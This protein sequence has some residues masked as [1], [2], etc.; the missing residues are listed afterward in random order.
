MGWGDDSFGTIGEPLSKEARHRLTQ[1]CLEGIRREIRPMGLA[2]NSR[3]R[4]PSL[5]A[6]LARGL[7]VAQKTVHRWTNPDG[8]QANDAN[9]VNLARLS[10]KYDPEETA[11]VLQEDVE[12]YRRT[13]LVWLKLADSNISPSP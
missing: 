7:G 12:K 5:E 8:I 11:R 13:V 4:P 9:A 6:I 1:I 2:K 10:Y 3:G